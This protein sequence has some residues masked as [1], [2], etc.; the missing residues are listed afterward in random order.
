MDWPEWSRRA[1]AQII[2]ARGASARS[3]SVRRGSPMEG[4]ADG[5]VSVGVSFGFSYLVLPWQRANRVRGTVRQA[6]EP[7]L[8]QL[9]RHAVGAAN[10]DDRRVR[11][12]DAENPTGRLLGAF[13]MLEGIAFVAI[14]TAAITST[15]VARAEAQRDAEAQ[16]QEEPRRGSPRFPA[17]GSVRAHGPG[18]AAADQAHRGVTVVEQL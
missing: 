7:I 11:R 4:V 2:R 13:V 6:C 3:S 18:Q 16:A 8:E 1:L 5:G 12:R 9:A 15:S 17:E 14:V 10:G